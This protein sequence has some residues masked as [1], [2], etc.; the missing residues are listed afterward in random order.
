METRPGDK[1]WLVV[2]KKNAYNLLGITRC[3][4]LSPGM[5]YFTLRF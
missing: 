4:L 2:T 1:E 5:H 3:I